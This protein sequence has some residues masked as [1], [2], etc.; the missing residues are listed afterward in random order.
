MQSVAVRSEEKG[1]DEMLVA[2]GHSSGL[3]H[4]IRIGFH[5]GRFL[6]RVLGIASV[7]SVSNLDIFKID[8]SGCSRKSVMLGDSS[9]SRW[10]IEAGRQTPTAVVG[11]FLPGG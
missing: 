4:R 2:C 7:A 3:C 11:E 9:E 5:G 6:L 10:F 8:L 1:A